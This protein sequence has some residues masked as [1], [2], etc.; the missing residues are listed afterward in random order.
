MIQEPII[1][2]STK[3]PKIKFL[4]DLQQKSSE[5]R[6]AGLFV[7][8]GCREL[9]HCLD[10]GYEVDSVFLSEEADLKTEFLHRLATAGMLY[11]VT[12]QVYE[13]M[14]YRGSTEGIVAIVKSRQLR[15]EE[16]HLPEHPLIVVLE[17]VEQFQEYLRE[18]ADDK[19]IVSVVL[20]LADNGTDAEGGDQNG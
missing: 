1:L 6:K 19:S 13:K 2:S 8:E 20:E 15:L 12:P 11:R 4:L 17:S 14:A 3:N 9:V 16:L 18:N 5:R 7:V 10:A